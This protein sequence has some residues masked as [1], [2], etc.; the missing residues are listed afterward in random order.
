MLNSAD[1]GL[2][3]VFT[4][5]YLFKNYKEPYYLPR[6]IFFT[7][8]NIQRLV[9]SWPKVIMFTVVLNCLESQNPCV[10]WYHLFFASLSMT[11][12][13]CK[14]R[15]QKPHLLAIELQWT[16]QT[17]KAY[18]L[19]PRVVSKKSV[20]VSDHSNCLLKYPRLIPGLEISTDPAYSYPDP[21][22]L[23][24]VFYLDNQSARHPEEAW[25]HT[26]FR[27]SSY[28]VSDAIPQGS[29]T[30]N[31][32]P[33]ANN[34]CQGG[35]TQL[36]SPQQA[37]FA[38]LN[39]PAAGPALTT[40]TYVANNA[41]QG[42]LTQLS[43]LPDASSTAH[44]TLMNIQAVDTAPVPTTIS[45]APVLYRTAQFLRPLLPSDHPS[46]FLTSFSPATTTTGLP[47]TASSATLSSSCLIPATASP[48]IAN[49]VAKNA[50]FQATLGGLTTPPT[51]EALTR[52]VVPGLVIPQ[53][54]S[55][56]LD[57]K[58]RVPYDVHSHL[59][60][61]CTQCNYRRRDCDLGQPCN[62]CLEDVA[63]GKESRCGYTYK[64]PF[65]TS[66]RPR[67]RKRDAQLATVEIAKEKGRLI[68]EKFEGQT[69]KRKMVEDEGEDE[70]GDEEG[71]EWI[72]KG[73]K[74]QKK[75]PDLGLGSEVFA[76]EYS[77]CI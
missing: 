13:K 56:A 1:R 19:S 66:G 57:R 4:L 69:L 27:T 53:S 31:T 75:W 9:Q 62:R 45:P 11:I 72:E 61:G 76:A 67:G 33:A 26:A 30:Q 68:R 32:D 15:S 18:R 2:D 5:V 41:S 7:L 71:G 16:I 6:S 25:A 70:E 14:F 3:K 73:G 40:L 46:A 59:R 54:N 29:A 37:S 44:Q 34:D 64:Q 51:G 24:F 10:D 63:A 28:R 8:T 52:I 39:A 48:S 50:A 20:S 17:I 42:N 35:S 23:G 43:S 38:A 12:F 36:S 49:I 55:E 74:K 47:R 77:S 65:S 58:G 22:G 21:E 60:L